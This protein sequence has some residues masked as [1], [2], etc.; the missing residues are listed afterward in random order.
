MTIEQWFGVLSHC[1]GCRA[2]QQLKRKKAGINMYEISDLFV[3]PWTKGTG[4][5]LAVLLS[6][7]KETC[8]QLMLS[9]CWAEDDQELLMSVRSFVQ[10]HFIPKSAALWFCV[11]SNYQPEDG[12]GPSLMEQLKLKPFADVIASPS[13]CNKAGGYGVVAVHTTA[14]NLYTRLWCVH[15]VERAHA[16]DDILVRAAM[17]DEYLEAMTDR[18]KMMQKFGAPGKECLEAAGVYVSTAQAR[19]SQRADELMLVEQVMRQVGSFRILDDIISKFRTEV[20]PLPILRSLVI[21]SELSLQYANMAARADKESVLAAVARESQAFT[22]A[23]KELQCDKEVRAVYA[24]RKVVEQL[25]SKAGYYTLPTAFPWG[26]LIRVSSQ[27]EDLVIEAVRFDAKLQHDILVCRLQPQ[28]MS[29]DEVPIVKVVFSSGETIDGVRLLPPP[30]EVPGVLLEASSFELSEQVVPRWIQSLGGFVL[31]FPKELGSKDADTVYTAWE[32]SAT[33]GEALA[34]TTIRMM[35]QLFEGHRSLPL[36]LVRSPNPAR[37]GGSD[38]PD[39]AAGLYVGDYGSN[40]GQFCHEVLLLEFRRCYEDEVHE[41]FKRPFENQSMVPGELLNI[42]KDKT[43]QDMQLGFLIAKKVT[44]DVNVPAGQA[45]FVALC[46][47]TEARQNLSQTLGTDVSYEHARSN[48]LIH[49]NII[50][51]WPG[52]MTLAAPGFKHVSWQAAALAHLESDTKGQDRF[53]MIHWQ[54]LKQKGMNVLTQIGDC[55]VG[56]EQKSN[57]VPCVSP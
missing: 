16:Q 29:D 10:V 4:C 26:L 52:F 23:S 53:A 51:Y 43:L 27:A 3:K 12:T 34:P 11:F 45:S 35:R 25:A 30:D 33:L 6:K 48:N 42:F 5:S 1:Q 19:C 31:D 55:G 37:L 24:K 17:S 44:G 9:H 57:S 21:E 18:V 2:Y 32:T 38:I 15:E 49:E 41:L 8:A 50:S 13:L 14:A 7:D 47:P 28:G 36:S 22:F 54:S 39:I 46:S 56:S 40:Y 20:L